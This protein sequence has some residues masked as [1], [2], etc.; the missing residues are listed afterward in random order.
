MTGW[1]ADHAA[2]AELIGTE[3][4]CHWY[5]WEQEPLDTGDPVYTPR[6]G[7]TE[8]VAALQ[9]SGSVHVVPCKH[10]SNPPLL[11]I[12][13]LISTELVTFGSIL[14]GFL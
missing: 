10:T 3:I 6:K 2:L 8:A 5:A 9:A 4:G 12:Y 14:T 11:V 13:E 1:L 7:F